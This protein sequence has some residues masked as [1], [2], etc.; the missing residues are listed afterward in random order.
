[1]F[2]AS[3][4]VLK[5]S[6]KGSVPFKNSLVR[7]LYPMQ[8]TVRP[9]RWCTQSA[10][11]QGGVLPSRRGIGMSNAL[12]IPQVMHLLDYGLSALHRTCTNSLLNHNFA[13]D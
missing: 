4:R 11:G 12:H 7:T 10:T 5:G 3:R 6:K 1:M 9:I 2:T 13:F 8:H